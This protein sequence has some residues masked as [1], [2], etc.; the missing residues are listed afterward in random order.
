MKQHQR[1]QALIET[2]LISL[3][4]LVPLIWTL[5]VLADLHRA[6][7][8]AT[9]AARDAGAEA[10]GART[11]LSVRQAID[12]AIARAFESH[13]LD[14]ELARVHTRSDPSLPRGS[15]VSIEIKFPVTVLQAPFLGR[16]SGPSI[17]VEAR[18][19]TRVPLFGSRR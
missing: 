4:L 8:A 9:S 17:W 10:V 3:I 13:Q 15:A 1:G 11:A 2:I 16:V 6:A 18:H 5:G 12:R 19:V 14:P 7:L